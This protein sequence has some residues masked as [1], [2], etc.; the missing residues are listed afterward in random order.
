MT[1]KSTHIYERFLEQLIPYAD[2]FPDKLWPS[3]KCDWRTAKR[4]EESVCAA[5]VRFYK[6]MKL[7]TPSV[8]WCDNPWQLATWPLLLQL[9]YLMYCD[10]ELGQKKTFLEWIQSDSSFPT[11]FGAKLSV[12]KWS[13]AYTCLIAE[14]KKNRH[15]S[16]SRLLQSN[17]DSFTWL[18]LGANPYPYLLRRSAS[19]TLGLPTYRFGHVPQNTWNSLWQRV[20]QTEAEL[21]QCRQLAE[22]QVFNETNQ[23]PS[24]FL[25]FSR[26]TPGARNFGGDTLAKQLYRQ[27]EGTHLGTKFWDNATRFTKYCMSWGR[28]SP[29][30]RT[31]PLEVLE[32]LCSGELAD[33][34][35]DFIMVRD[36]AFLY[37]FMQEV[38]FACRNPVAIHLDERHRLHCYEKPA[39]E[40][41]DGYCI[42]SW[43]GVMVSRQLVD[44]PN[45]LTVKYIQTT[46]N[47]E[48]RRVLI[49]RYGSAKYVVDAGAAVIDRSDRGILYRIDMPRDEALVMVQVTNSTPEPDGTCKKY[50]LRVPPT[51]TSAQ[52]AVAWTFA[53]DANT[54]QPEIET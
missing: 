46:T 31:T 17:P 43:H 30:G 18:D 13:Q 3:A 25:N 19:G 28:W 4:D 1:S 44:D 8:L 22:G 16:F 51:V 24:D 20:D 50:F 11:E 35:Q 10:C 52:E 12:P 23:R 26:F 41:P 42:C 29:S 54:Y 5:I 47:V 37:V 36:A 27:L 39:V 15:Q 6:R 45:L 48:L 21:N 14:L 38:V 32:G 53:I 49:D 33:E 2:D 7:D 40:F 34:L 9:I